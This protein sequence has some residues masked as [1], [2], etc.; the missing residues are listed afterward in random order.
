MNPYQG[1]N[2]RH[3]PSSRPPRPPLHREHG[4]TG[5]TPINASPHQAPLNSF[6]PLAGPAASFSST[7]AL[8]SVKSAPRMSDSPPRKRSSSSS[9]A[10]KRSSSSRSSS[11]SSSSR[12]R[13]SRPSREAT[14]KDEN[15]SPQ[16]SSPAQS[17]TPPPP[18]DSPSP[19]PDSSDSPPEQEAPRRR[20]SSSSSSS[21][22]SPRRSPSRGR[23]R[24]SSSASSTP[25]APPL[26][27]DT[28]E[29]ADCAW[30]IYLAELTEEGLTI[31]DNSDCDSLAKR[32]FEMA[33]VFLEHRDRHHPLS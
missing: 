18:A 7:A 24:Q 15:E 27:L 20:S 32:S 8:L 30:E 1:Q 9:S 10:R 11:R 23:E 33:R 26:K 12:S 25:S 6:Q 19:S 4:G 22:S 28:K 13:T 5:T 21:S 16:P 14:P 2:G 17:E 3:R 31:F 29:L